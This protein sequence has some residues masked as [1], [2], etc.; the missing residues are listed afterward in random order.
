MVLL[1]AQRF[2]RGL[3]SQLGGFRNPGEQNLQCLTNKKEESLLKHVF[4]FLLQRK[5]TQHI[6]KT[7]N[8]T[9]YAD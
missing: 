6:Y 8:S 3:S 2:S 4:F 9:N 1:K 7:I 5:I